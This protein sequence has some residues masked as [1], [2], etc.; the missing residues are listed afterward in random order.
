MAP[1]LSGSPGIASSSPVKN[2]ATR[3]RRTTSSFAW[4]TD[5]ASPSACGVSRVPAGRITLPASI[6]SPARRTHSPDCGTW[7]TITSSPSA[8]HCS[9]ITTA[10]AP[11]GINPPVKMRAAVPGSSAVPTWPAGIRCDTR[12]RVP[13][14]GTSAARMA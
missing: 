7:L 11:G 4:P 10:S 14:A 5:A 3:T 8:V 9:C 12:S 13:A 1:G 6:S 2:T